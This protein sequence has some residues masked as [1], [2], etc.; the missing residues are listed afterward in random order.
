MADEWGPWVEHD[1]GPCPVPPETWVITQDML[2]EVC[3]GPAGEWMEDAEGEDCWAWAGD[4]SLAQ[5]GIAIIRY[6]LRR[7][8]AIQKLV[9]LVEGLPQPVRE[10]A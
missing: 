4:E 10:D 8:P 2:A 7:P 9:D 3:E 1:G 6:R 5:W